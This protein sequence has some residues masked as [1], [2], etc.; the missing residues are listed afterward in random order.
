MKKNIPLFKVR[1]AEDVGDFVLPV[2]KSGYIGEGPKVVEFESEL[3][4]RLQNEHVV[5]TNSATSAEHLALHLLKTTGHMQE[6]DE[7]LA[8]PLTCTATNWPI[9]ANGFK[10]RWVDVDPT[11]MN[12][13]LDDLANKITDRTKAIMIVHW[14][15][16]PVDLQKLH[17][18]SSWFRV[19]R[20]HSLKIIQ[21]CAHAMGTQYWDRP[22]PFYGDMCTFS[23]QAIKHMTCGDGGALT[24]P[25]KE[26]YQKAK[27]G[28][29]YGIDRDG[30][31]A[32]FRCESDISEWGFKFHMN[33]IAASIGLANIRYLDDTLARQS[34]N[35]EYYYEM[36]PSEGIALP[37]RLPQGHN[38]AWWLFTL[39]V[40]RRDDF[41]KAMLDRGVATSRVHERNDKH[42]CVEEFKVDL[43]GVDK[44]VKNMVCIPV[45]WW[46]TPEDREY[47]V[48]CIKKGW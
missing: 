39:R 48:D 1:M 28:R 47:I 32:E 14:G 22:I 4:K 38:P 45:G 6:G 43:P 42:S 12:M 29:W 15:G 18:L 25:D 3:K 20:G 31:R 30:P 7:V 40:D 44:A 37:P 17:W 11:T 24:L 23:F 27:L 19:K 2:L 10:I 8:S 5:T 13:D 41:M 33:D 36:L 34:M 35:A 21:D 16:Y 26:L 9:L 46:V